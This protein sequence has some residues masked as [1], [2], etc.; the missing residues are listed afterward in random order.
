ML[1]APFES[2]EVGEWEQMIDV[3]LRGLIRTGRAFVDDLLAA[4]EAGERADLIH[5]D[6]VGGHDRSSTTA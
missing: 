4:A 6:S 1:G 5:V 2:A 3:N